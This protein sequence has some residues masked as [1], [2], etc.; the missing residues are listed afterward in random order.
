[1]SGVMITMLVILALLLLVSTIFLLKDRNWAAIVDPSGQVNSGGF[2][3]IQIGD[4][5]EQ[6][7]EKLVSQG[8][9]EYLLPGDNSCLMRGRFE[10]MISFT[11]L[12]WRRGN[13]CIGLRDGRVKSVAWRYNVFQP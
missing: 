3:S 12:S 6:A 9:I 10:E 4:S 2:A 8:L 13:I 11:D 1:M 5:E 7:R